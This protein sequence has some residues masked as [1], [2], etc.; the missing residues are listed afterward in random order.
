MAH[1][2]RRVPSR[3]ERRCAGPNWTSTPARSLLQSRCS[4]STSHRSP[5]VAPSSVQFPQMSVSGPSADCPIAVQE[6]RKPT[7]GRRPRWCRPGRFHPHQTCHSRRSRRRVG[8]GSHPISGAHMSDDDSVVADGTTRG[9]LGLRRAPF[10]T[11]API[12]G[13]DVRFIPARRR[14]EG[15]CR[16]LPDPHLLGSRSGGSYSADVPTGRIRMR[17]RRES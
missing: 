3:I 2:C 15:L 12:V 11:R 5:P 10:G 14:C 8:T 1:A 13:R 4:R 9:C 7:F 6:R 17:S 16:Q